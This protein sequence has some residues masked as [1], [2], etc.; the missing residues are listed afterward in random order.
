MN[1]LIDLG[2]KAIRVDDIKSLEKDTIAN[3]KENCI[4]DVIY[5]HLY[6]DNIPICLQFK[7]DIR[8]DAEYLSLLNEINKGSK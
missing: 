6:N 3:E 8:R 4:C 1:K 2:D 7:N 5:I